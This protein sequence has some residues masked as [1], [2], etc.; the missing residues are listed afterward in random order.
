MTKFHPEQFLAEM[1]HLITD[2]LGLD[3]RVLLADLKI[4]VDAILRGPSQ[5]DQSWRVGVC[6]LIVGVMEQALVKRNID[7]YLRW[8]AADVL[9]EDS[10]SPPIHGK[11]GVRH[12]LDEMLKV[13]ESAQFLGQRMYAYPSAV[14]SQSQRRHV[15][16]A[17]T[18]MLEVTPSGGSPKTIAGVDVFDF[19]PDFQIERVTS[20]YEPAP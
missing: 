19:A 7:V 2:V 11:I 10:S 14:A 4:D 9:F 20:F 8:V 18:F 17:M 3:M 12:F 5:G 15:R 1:Q 13:Y 16:V 6:K